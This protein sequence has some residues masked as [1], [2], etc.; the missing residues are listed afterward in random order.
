[1]AGDNHKRCH[2]KSQ[3]GPLALRKGASTRRHHENIASLWTNSG[4]GRSFGSARIGLAHQQ[5]DQEGDANA[6]QKRSRCELC[7]FQ[8]TRNDPGVQTK[9][10]P[11]AG[12]ADHDAA[13]NEH[14][15]VDDG[16]GRADVPRLDNIGRGAKREYVGQVAEPEQEAQQDVAGGARRLGV[17]QQRQSDDLYRDADQNR[18]LAT[19]KIVRNPGRDEA[20]GL[21]PKPLR[22]ALP[23][24]PSTS[25]LICGRDLSLR[26][27]VL[28]NRHTGYSLR[29]P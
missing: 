7:Q 11:H 17:E 25:G 22:L 27:S 4:T 15:A 8:R 12:P 18:Q 19:L 13:E 29:R 26:R 1:M 10:D 21:V 9:A 14:D 20:A 23:A 6:N 5:S 2:S 24:D 3:K 28:A 16:R